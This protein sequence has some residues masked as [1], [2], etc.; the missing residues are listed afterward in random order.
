[1]A[2]STVTLNQRLAGTNFATID[3]VSYLL[4]EGTWRV[5]TPER[6]SQ[7]GEDGVHGYIERP[8]IG[9]IKVKLRDWGGNKVSTIGNITNSNVV[10]SL[11]NGKNIVGANMW[12]TEQLVT[13]LEDGTF[14]ATFESGSVTEN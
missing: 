12:A 14:E 6:E 2:Q 7:R 11:S 5:S 4:V 9:Q 1:M 10:L 3:G 13:S 8:G